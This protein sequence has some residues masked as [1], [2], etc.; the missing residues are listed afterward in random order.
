[1]RQYFASLGKGDQASRTSLEGVL[2]RL[3]QF[4]EG[5]MLQQYGP[6][7]DSLAIEDLGLLG[8][9]DDAWGI[10]ALAV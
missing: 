10:A 7:V 4:E 2:L 1:L 5:Q 8:S 9:S 6:G 3:E